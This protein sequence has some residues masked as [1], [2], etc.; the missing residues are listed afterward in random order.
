MTLE[1]AVLELDADV[2]PNTSGKDL[3]VFEFKGDLEVNQRLNVDHLLS[4]E[5]G[6][7]NSVVTSTPGI[8]ANEKR[9]SFFLDLGA[10]V[11][12]HEINFLGWEGSGDKYQF[13]DGTG[14]EQ[15]DATGEGPYHQMQCFMQYLR[16]GEY[17]SRDEHARLR[18][19]EYSD[20]R[21]S[22]DGVDG[23]YDDYLHVTVMNMSNNRQAEQPIA[24]NGSLLLI[25]T[26]DLTGPVDVLFEQV[27][28]GA[29]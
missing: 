2:N 7:I 3:G 28:E 14:N 8:V 29:Q 15:A 18:I 1:H 20:G 24:F 25:E 23:I 12:A 26:Q 17:D 22:E 19:G 9:V 13:G 21:Y 5:Y 27:P 6:N 11:H 16:T 10:G 4:H